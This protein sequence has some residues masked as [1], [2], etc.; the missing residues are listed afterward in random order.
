MKSYLHDL[1]IVSV[2]LLIVISPALL[3]TGLILFPSVTLHL[4]IGAFFFVPCGF[5]LG[6]CWSGGQ[7]FYQA[8][9]RQAQIEYLERSWQRSIQSR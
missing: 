3:V 1:F 6:I 5:L 8:A 9:S 2:I 4:F 7:R